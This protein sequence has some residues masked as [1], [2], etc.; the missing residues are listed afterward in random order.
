MKRDIYIYTDDWKSIKQFD[1]YIF[2]KH[3]Q[4]KPVWIE[5]KEKQAAYTFGKGPTSLKMILQR[6]FGD[7][8]QA[9][10]LG[11]GVRQKH[12][13]TTRI[14]P[15]HPAFGKQNIMNLQLIVKSFRNIKLSYMQT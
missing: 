12:H 13:R 14:A 3:N 11:S 1:T 5:F 8:C 7:S 6:R 4:T 2:S 10:I 15:L 9:I